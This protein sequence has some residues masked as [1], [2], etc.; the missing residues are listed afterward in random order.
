MP[1]PGYIQNFALLPPAL[2]K[3]LPEHLTEAVCR[4]GAP[5]AEELRLYAGRICTITAQGK[6]Y[7]T[8]V[9]L[10]AAELEA[11]L[12]KLCRGSLY[13]YSQSINRG[14]FT[15]FPGLRVGVCGHAA[16]EHGRVIGVRDV[17]SLVLRIPHGMILPAD[18]VLAAIRSHRRGVLLFSPPGVGKTTM[19]R[20]IAAAAASPRYRMRTVVVDS[21][22]EIGWGLD[23]KDLLLDILMGYPRDKGIEIALCSLGAEL[24]LCDE[25]STEEDALSILSAAGCGVPIVASTHGGT[26]DEIFSRPTIQRLHASGVFGSYVR[27]RREGDQ[28]LSYRFLRP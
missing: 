7:D 5:L 9:I 18:D 21:R 22:E 23:G 25:I 1:E 28:P 16:I 14:Y 4:S 12:L 26:L 11:I 24:I 17:T 13:A 27:L 10:S 15:P 20:S 6:N 8:S 2:R 3:V 19:L